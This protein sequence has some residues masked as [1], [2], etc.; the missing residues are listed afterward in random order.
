MIEVHVAD[1]LAARADETLRECGTRLLWREAGAEGEAKLCAVV[2]AGRSGAVLDRLHR[3]LANV[4]GLRVLV[5]PL[6][7]TLPAPDREAGEPQG[8]PGR[9]GVSVEEIQA[10][11]AGESR[12]SLH[13]VAL[14]ALSTLVAAI[15]LAKNNTAAVIGAMVVA[16]LLG[17][18]MGLA[19]GLTLGEPALVRSAF[20]TAL[21]GLALALASALLLGFALDVDPGVPEI[22]SRAR[23]DL[24]DILLALAA[25][26]AGTLA[27]TTGAPAYLIGVMVAVALLPPTVAAGLLA[28]QG[29]LQAA[30]GA[31]LLVLAN[32]TAVNLAAMLT[33]VASGIRP[34]EWWTAE[35]A[36]RGLLVGILVWSALLAVLASAILVSQRLP[37]APR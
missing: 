13:F 7:A 2:D 12:L 27:Y 22:A 29:E 3:E 36:R 6:D 9:A 4:G 24:Q 8:E 32:V 25:G 10:R 15:G 30:A 18:N 21:C 23:V 19:L 33:L 20:R 37:G 11:I 5:L 28:S 16:P 31:G 26:A 17:P 1:D 14:V 34:R 35:R